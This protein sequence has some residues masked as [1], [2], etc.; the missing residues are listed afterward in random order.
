MF[1]YTQA[2]L[3]W[4]LVGIVT[5]IIDAKL[6][7]KAVRVEDVISSLGFGLFGFFLPLIVILNFLITKIN[8]LYKKNRNK[9]IF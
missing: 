9:K 3:F 7:R 8:K 6:C 4:Y 2:F 5:W 1:T